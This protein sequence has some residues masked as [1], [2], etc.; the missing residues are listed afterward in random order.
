MYPKSCISLINQRRLVLQ[1]EGVYVVVSTSII[2]DLKVLLVDPAEA[3]ATPATQTPVSVTFTPRPSLLTPQPSHEQ[4][5]TAHPFDVQPS[6]P[7][8]WRVHFGQKAPR[9][10][11]A[12]RH[13]FTWDELRTSPVLDLDES[14]VCFQILM[15]QILRLSHFCYTRLIILQRMSHHLRYAPVAHHEWA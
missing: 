13:S 3:P 6:P 2:D 11:S 1:P 5:R 14:C 9:A 4:M 15:S 10:L 8:E 7:P 12:K